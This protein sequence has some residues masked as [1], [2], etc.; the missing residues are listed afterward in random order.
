MEDEADNMQAMISKE[1]RGQIATL[2]HH[3]RDCNDRMG[4]E[5][6]PAGITTL[7][8]LINMA[9]GRCRELRGELANS[10]QS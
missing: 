4:N 8:M 10:R 5:S 3:I 2:E 7:N 6:T 9:E 1:R